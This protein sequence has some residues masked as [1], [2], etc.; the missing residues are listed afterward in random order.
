MS[1]QRRSRTNA[2]SP[3]PCVGRET[4]R[5][6]LA[7]WVS[8]GGAR[9]VHVWG[10]GG[11]GKSTLVRAFAEDHVERG[12]RVVQLDAPSARTVNELLLRIHDAFGAFAD[13]ELDASAIL[14]RIH[15]KLSNRE[16]TVI[17]LDG[18]DARPGIASRLAERWRDERFEGALVLVSRS[19]GD[20]V[21]ERSLEVKPL[22][23]DGALSC[24]LAHAGAHLGSEGPAAEGEPRGDDAA[25]SSAPPPIDRDALDKVT[26][27]CAGHPLAIGLA[28]ARLRTH[29]VA[30]VVDWLRRGSRTNRERIGQTVRDAYRELEEDDRRAL[31]LLRTLGTSP[32]LPLTEHVF[33]AGRCAPSLTRLRRAGIAW[34]RP[35]RS[36]YSAAD[37]TVWVHDA[38]LNLAA[39]DM[40][41]GA[42]A[43]AIAGIVREGIVSFGE[44]L[45]DDLGRARA[46]D[47]IE[48]LNAI[49]PQ[50]E[51]ILE[52]QTPD[53]V[54]ARAALLLNCAYDFWIP[55]RRAALL[56]R[57]LSGARDDAWLEM[58]IRLSRGRAVLQHNDPERAMFDVEAGRAAALSLGSHGGILLASLIETL[59]VVHLGQLARAREQAL[60]T[61]ALSDGFDVS[62]ASEARLLLAYTLHLT[63]NYAEASAYAEEA[64]ALAQQAD[65][66]R[67]LAYAAQLRAAMHLHAGRTD[68]ALRLYLLSY[69]AT[70]RVGNALL[71]A[72]AIRGFGCIELARGNVARAVRFC[73]RAEA[74]HRK[75]DNTRERT[76]TLVYLGVALIAAGDTMASIDTLKEA[77]GSG[78]TRQHAV[79]AL[80][81]LAFAQ[82]LRG[83]NDAALEAL[84][85]ARKRL[86]D[87]ADL[88]RSIID[89]V[90]RA[91]VPP[92]EGRDLG[93]TAAPAERGFEVSVLR[94]LL[95]ERPKLQAIPTRARQVAL[96][97]AWFM[98]YDGAIVSLAKRPA[99]Q[100]FL[101]TL[102]QGVRA[103]AGPLRARALYDASWPDEFATDAAAVNR[104]RVSIWSLR[105]MGLIGLESSRAGYWLDSVDIVD[106][107]APRRSCA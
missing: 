50:L 67:L 65:D 23:A 15:R 57:A 5:A 97:G 73:R 27:A 82:W 22:D 87:G 39:R 62:F 53:R 84:A 71:G 88:E 33:A 99:L 83:A 64:V 12:G 66:P 32:A 43:E 70:R 2:A 49:R 51:A 55:R 18:V 90:E 81:F 100:R 41:D 104:V 36:Q 105:R 6:L 38:F 103:G 69:R 30:S 42:H 1:K 14:E 77:L 19:A 107:D 89:L 60:H 11:L 48:Q 92:P 85:E 9:T 13:L 25:P 79:I 72:V 93:E 37:T 58:R 101:A 106:D 94:R 68:D 34:L 95:A 16:G 78:I 98:A 52:E 63:S 80:G 59:C 29:D 44:S 3:T 4:E 61:I 102:A 46:K 35:P 20:I 24:A 31:M 7:E 86:V 76:N 8:S 26:R 45:V 17:V 91:V 10:A 75:L 28:V 47:S 54:W 56:S 96:S 74:V 40:E 21:A